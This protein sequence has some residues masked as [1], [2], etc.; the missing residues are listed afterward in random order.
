MSINQ[1]ITIA[2]KG[3]DSSPHPL[4]YITFKKG[5]NSVKCIYCGKIFKK[6][7]LETD[8]NKDKEKSN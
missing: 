6:E 7:N 2:C 8:E 1:K 5:E 4:I 3:E